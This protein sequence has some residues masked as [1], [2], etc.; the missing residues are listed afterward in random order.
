MAAQTRDI[1]KSQFEADDV[2]PAQA[3]IDLIDSF[4]LVLEGFVTFN[5]AVVVH[6]DDVV[7]LT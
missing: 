4:V 1:L 6:D 5:D 2:P 3:W 7:V